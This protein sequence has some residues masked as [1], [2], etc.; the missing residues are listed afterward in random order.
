MDNETK[1]LLM[2]TIK[3]IE[4]VNHL[5]AEVGAIREGM[6]LLLKASTTFP[7]GTTPE[8]YMQALVDTHM[9]ETQPALDKMKAALQL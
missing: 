6:I 5:R 1:A 2:T 3:T 4:Q 7:P 8:Q 9:A